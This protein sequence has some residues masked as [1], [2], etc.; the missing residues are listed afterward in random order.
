MVYDS[1]EEISFWPISGKESLMVNGGIV[2]ALYLACFK[3]KD[4]Y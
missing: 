1:L 4:I 2:K 3:T